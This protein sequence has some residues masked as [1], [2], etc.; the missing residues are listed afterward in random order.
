MTSLSLYK[1]NYS[2][3]VTIATQKVETIIPAL[4]EETE[5][6]LQLERTLLEIFENFKTTIPKTEQDLNRYHNHLIRIQAEARGIDQSPVAATAENCFQ[7]MKSIRAYFEARP[8]VEKQQLKL[9]KYTDDTL[10]K[11]PKTLSDLKEE[12]QKKIYELSIHIRSLKNAKFNFSLVETRA[13]N[14]DQKKK[15]PFLGCWWIRASKTLSIS[16]TSQ[17]TH[18]QEEWVLVPKEMGKGQKDLLILEQQDTLPIPFFMQNLIKTTRLT[19]EQHPEIGKHKQITNSEV[20]TIET[21]LRYLQSNNTPPNKTNLKNTCF[22]SINKYKTAEIFLFHLIKQL[23]QCCELIE[24]AKQYRVS[25][26]TQ[27]TLKGLGILTE[28]ITQFEDSFQKTKELLAIQESSKQELERALEK[29][30]SALNTALCYANTDENTL[31]ILGK[32]ASYFQRGHPYF[33]ALYNIRGS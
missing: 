28:Q 33:D 9:F 32:V 11:I 12:I 29:H 4:A 7:E 14:L 17:S 30:K 15:H 31:S 22:L 10:N 3:L 21:H 8:A 26:E 24:N 16:N 13:S 27:E 25:S 1:E 23:E 6:L 5:S 18:Q 20:Q 2:L 19:E